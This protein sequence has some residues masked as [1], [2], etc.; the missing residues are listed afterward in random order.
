[1]LPIRVCDVGKPTP[2]YKRHSTTSLLAALEMAI[3]HIT[4]TCKPRRRR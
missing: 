1:M 2:D 4:G 3:A